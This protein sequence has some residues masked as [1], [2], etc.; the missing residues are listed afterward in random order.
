MCTLLD[1]PDVGPDAAGGPVRTRRLH[2][3]RAYLSSALVRDRGPDL[4]IFCTAWRVRNTTGRF[5][6]DQFSLDFAAGQLTCPAE[7]AMPF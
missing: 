4:A 7:V 6:K 2:I 1:F 5:P 3:D